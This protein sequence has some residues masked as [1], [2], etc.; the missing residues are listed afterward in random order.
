MW[1]AS[2]GLSGVMFIFQ[3]RTFGALRTLGSGAWIAIGVWLVLGG[4]GVYWQSQGQAKRD[5]PDQTHKTNQLRFWQ[6][7]LLALLVGSG[8]VGF[9]G[10][11]R[12]S[13]PFI[14]L[15]LPNLDNFEDLSLERHERLLVLALHNGDEVLGAAGMIMQAVDQGL[16]VHVVFMTDGDGFTFSTIQEFETLFPSAQ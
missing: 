4:L 9:L 11:L 16:E 13:F 14:T 3:G 12:T 2:Y 1:C 6:T 15:D 7:A 10:M 5:N 8:V